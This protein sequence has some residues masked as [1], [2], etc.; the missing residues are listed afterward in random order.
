MSMRKRENKHFTKSG[1]EAKLNPADS[2]KSLKNSDLDEIQKKM[3][4]K[5]EE[6]SYESSSKNKSKERK[7]ALQNGVFFDPFGSVETPMQKKSESQFNKHFGSYL[8]FKFNEGGKMLAMDEPENQKSLLHNLKRYKFLKKAG[9]LP[10]KNIGMQKNRKASR[11][12]SEGTKKAHLSKKKEDELLLENDIFPS[13]RLGEPSELNQL[14][15][16]QATHSRVSSEIL[17]STSHPNTSF[18]SNKNLFTN[19]IN[20]NIL[21]SKKPRNYKFETPN[22][23]RTESAK[24]P[25]LR[26]PTWQKKARKGL[27]ESD[28]GWAP[29]SESLFTLTPSK[30]FPNLQKRSLLEI[31]ET[32]QENENNLLNKKADDSLNFSDSFSNFKMFSKKSKKDSFLTN[33]EGNKNKFEIRLDRFDSLFKSDD[34]S[35]LGKNLFTENLPPAKKHLILNPNVVDFEENI[36]DDIFK[37]ERPKKF[38]GGQSEFPFRLGPQSKKSKSSSNEN[39]G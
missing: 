17:E 7:P 25:S 39:L 6:L 14:M 18:D 11:V 29:Y 22:P 1:K 4:E 10:L 38:L 20:E 37:Q 8:K 24:P 5:K 28:A 30:W 34:S 3:L 27:F 36:F 32:C 16:K 26:R 13:Q 2:S 35:E 33:E 9:M 31:R 21:N 23:N 15:K 12:V 19:Q